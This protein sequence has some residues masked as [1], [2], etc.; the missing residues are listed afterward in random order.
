[1]INVGRVGRE[2]SLLSLRALYLDCQ[3][4]TYISFYIPACTTPPPFSKFCTQLPGAYFF[5]IPTTSTDGKVYLLDIA[6]HMH[7]SVPNII[8]LLG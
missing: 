3:L 2:G 5:L 8:I 4:H 6:L 7:Y 1:M